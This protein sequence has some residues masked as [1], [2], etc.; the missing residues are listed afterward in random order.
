MPSEIEQVERKPGLW[1]VF[2]LTFFTALGT[3]TGF[4]RELVLAFFFGT[5][6]SADAFAVAFFYYEFFYALIIGG[7]G[8]LSIVPFLARTRGRGEEEQGRRVV[9]TTALW[10]GIFATCLAVG[11]ML[12]AGELVG[13]TLPG[14]SAEQ[15]ET[16]IG[17]I[18]ICA[19]GIVPLVV[20]LLL[21]ARL[22]S[23]YRF[24][25]TPLGRMAQ[26]VGIV[27]TTLLFVWFWGVDAA[28]V[29]L[30]VG[31]LALLLLMMLATRGDKKV[32]LAPLFDRGIVELLKLM[33]VP[34]LLTVLL[35]FVLVMVEFYFL[36]PLGEGVIAAM[37]YGRRLLAIFAGLG[38]SI[39]IVY[40]ARAARE[41]EAN[42]DAARD[43]SL[44]ASTIRD[45][46]SIL[47]PASTLLLLTA[48]PLV[49][50]L[51]QRGSFG[52]ESTVLTSTALRCL[53]LGLL[54]HILYGIYIRAGILLRRSWIS[55]LMA[56]VLVA[57][58]FTFDLLTVAEYGLVGVALGYSVAKFVSS[59]FGHIAISRVL[60]GQKGMASSGLNAVADVVIALA[61]A[62]PV[63]WMAEQFFGG[64]PAGFIDAVVR[65][66]AISA[67]Y[68]AVYSLASIATRRTNVLRI[69]GR[70]LRRER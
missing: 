6:A 10:F 70:L 59:L 37:R 26:N 32:G 52:P 33:V 60:R 56:V 67:A 19:L 16:T 35:N 34:L 39:Q 25:L 45:T 49:Y 8:T 48:V 28:G 2:S 22:Q 68:L 62:A 65:M 17:L 36:A 54:G 13:V 53:A 41:S 69:A 55:L 4:F 40:F 51:F 18:R 43:A 61:C 64:L 27:A 30:V 63:W 11:A 9:N 47:A 31:A 44:L 20:G 5:S 29:G 7:L 57:M 14:L 12:F 21:A 24:N 3:A 23:Y 46:T 15:Y 50:I 58:A 42:R 1:A 66:V 38:Y